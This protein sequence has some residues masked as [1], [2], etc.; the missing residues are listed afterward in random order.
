MIKILLDTNIVLDIALQRHQFGENAKKLTLFIAKNRINS[1]VTASSITD[2]YYVLRKEKGH[3][4]S[5]QFL[6]NFIKLTK[7]IGID[8][9]IITNALNSKMNDFEDAVQTETAFINDIEIIFAY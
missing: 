7:V 4:N 2:I 1:Y 9:N 8:E 6:K 3:T 5:I